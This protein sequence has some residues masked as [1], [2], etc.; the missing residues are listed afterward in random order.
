VLSVARFATRFADLSGPVSRREHG[1][2]SGPSFIFQGTIVAAGAA[3]VSLVDVDELTAIVRVDRILRAPADME[4]IA[5]R[6]ITIQLREPADVGST[7]VFQANG[8]LYGESMA[9][10]EAGTRRTAGAEP[11]PAAAVEHEL[12]SAAAVDR[13]A[14]YRSALKT[15]AD[16]A[17]AVVVGRVTSVSQQQT[18]AAAGPEGHLSEH[19]PRWAV[20]TVEVDEAVKGR[21]AGTIEVLFASSED[22]MWRDAP[23][24]AVGQ[25]AVML[26]QR[27]APEVEDKRAHAVLH[28]LDVQPADSAEL[29]AT[30][31]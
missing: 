23:K 25:K 27:G 5:G 1:V 12:E 30:L 20:A 4:Q 16:E 21:P 6:E 29:V 24:L 26:L 14:R 3:N 22:V 18:A 31:L 10:V 2:S 19:D 7:A 15:R 8:W 9:V 13:A 11:G 17:S 28:K